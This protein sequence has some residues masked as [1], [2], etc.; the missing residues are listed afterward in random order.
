MRKL[1]LLALVLFLAPIAAFAQ[2]QCTNNV[3]N[4]TFNASLLGN[5]VVG[6]SGLN[7][8]FANATIVFNNNGQAVITSNTMGLNN[9]TG[10][11]LYQGAP[12]TNG[13]AVQ[14]FTT[15]TSNFT[16]G[17][18]NRTL[19]IDPSLLTA[20]E[21]NPQNYYFVITTADFPNGA[22]RGTLVPANA[23]QFG[24]TL[25]GGANGAPGGSGTF[26]FSLS[27]NPGGQTYTLTYDISTN[28]I[29]NTATGFTLTPLGGN[30]VTFAHGDTVVNGRFT[31]TT[32]ID[33]VTAQQL[34]CNPSAFSLGIA[35]QAFANGAVTGNVGTNNELFI[36]VVGS[37]PG[38]NNTM[39]RTDL[40]LYNNNQGTPATVYLQYFPEGP[41]SS[42]AL[43]AATSSINA[44]AAQVSTDIASALFNNALT[45]IGALRILTS[46]SVFANAR[47][48][49]DQ[50]AN[51]K[52]TFG[53]NVPG[54]TR[55]QAVSQ[56][57]LVGTVNSVTGNVTGS[58]N[59]R[60]NVGLFNP[61]DSPT[62]VAMQL[63]TN[64]G[65]TLAT[66]IITLA[67]WQHM[68]MPLAG[69]TGAAFPFITGDV[70]ASAV[71][72]LAGSPIYAYASVVDNVSG[73]GS[74]ILPSVGQTSS[75]PTQ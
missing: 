5:N 3:L 40:N 30:P 24:G 57:I 44:G 29:G 14:T 26:A 71:S 64:S 15:S 56:G 46:G 66:N 37:V 2:T 58:M 75:T 60:T 35:T 49:N 61:S 19:T 22:V 6:S 67:P 69:T 59:A 53:Q 73:D 18:L 12:G 38:L 45:G 65:A 52:G 47:I 7:N 13:T 55:A 27:P 72:F 20:I 8:G 31:G 63:R 28:G 25:S 10:I 34:L 21:A 32:T 17:Q 51:G 9:I 42:T 36:P 4:P 68:Q 62:S 33:M 39:W 48:Y 16:G 41:S 50:T 54:L 43:L 70:G 23:Q 11:T 74:F 1:S